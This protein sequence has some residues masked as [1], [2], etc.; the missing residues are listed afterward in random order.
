MRK[1]QAG[2]A[3]TRAQRRRNPEQLEPEPSTSSNPAKR[4]KPEPLPPKPP[5][6]EQE[7]TDEQMPPEQNE[8]EEADAEEPDGSPQ[9]RRRYQLKE[10]PQLYNHETLVAS[11]DLLDAYVIKEHHKRQKIF[12]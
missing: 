6:E 4:K 5:D 10:I 1:V 3:L 8:P 9:I 11:N 2:G 12:K 7:Q